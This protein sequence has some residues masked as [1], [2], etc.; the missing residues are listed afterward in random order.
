MSLSGDSEI[1]DETLNGDQRS[2]IA[3]EVEHRGMMRFIRRSTDGHDLADARKDTVI[4]QAELAIGIA[5]G[6]NVRYHLCRQIIP[7]L[8][9]HGLGGA[10]I[11]LGLRDGGSEMRS[12]KQNGRTDAAT[13][14]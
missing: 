5:N 12:P 4:E 9:A 11:R 1:G 14:L 3:Q 7:R 2:L 8:A 13:G 6:R 10:K